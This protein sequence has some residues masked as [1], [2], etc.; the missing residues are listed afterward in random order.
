MVGYKQLQCVKNRPYYTNYN[1]IVRIA[2]GIT[3]AISAHLP[4]SQWFPFH[5]DV[6]VQWFGAV[7]FPSCW[8]C[9]EQIAARVCNYSNI[10]W[11]STLFLVSPVSQRTPSHPER[12]EHW[13]GWKQFPPLPHGG[14]QIAVMGKEHWTFWHWCP[15]S[16][17]H[18]LIT[19]VSSPF[20]CTPT[21]SRHN[22]QPSIHAFRVACSWRDRNR[23]FT[24]T[25]FPGMYSLRRH[26]PMAT[27]H[28][29]LCCIGF[30]SNLQCS[31]TYQATY[32]FLHCYMEGCIQLQEKSTF[33]SILEY[34][35]LE[36]FSGNH[37]RHTD[38]SQ[39][40]MT[41]IQKLFPSGG[42]CLRQYKSV[43]ISIGIIIWLDCFLA[44]APSISYWGKEMFLSYL[45]TL[46]TCTPCP[47]SRANA[48]ICC[49]TMAFI[50]A[51]WIAGGCAWYDKTQS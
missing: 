49:C 2:L 19:V 35:G 43:H 26:T 41:L 48:D 50:F 29:N 18:T 32:R 1:I 10:V 4:F 16:L 15:L 27:H 38:V 45:A 8:Q 40:F 36:D 20:I 47:A 28:A 25:M 42:H 31:Y 13:L 37:V 33:L 12:Q 30:Q 24:Y 11:H 3:I 23:L 51:R 46:F 34:Y 17:K 6:Q 14:W 39:V 21:H 9:G 5:I 44:L 7:Q 22:T